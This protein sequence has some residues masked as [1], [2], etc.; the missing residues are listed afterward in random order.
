MICD[1]GSRLSRLL[2]LWFTTFE[3]ASTTIGAA[4][5]PPGKVGGSLHIPPRGGVTP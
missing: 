2:R 1:Y 5:L 4:D 3:L